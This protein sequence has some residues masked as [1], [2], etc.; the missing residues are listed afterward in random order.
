VQLPELPY[1][2]ADLPGIGGRWKD[3][4]EDFVVEEIPAYEPSGSGEHLFLWIEKRNVAAADL[5]RHVSR[6]LRCSPR[7]I[8]VA[9]L[10]D[11]RAI[12]RQYLSVSAKLAAEVPSIDTD[13]TEIN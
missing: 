8:G 9:G 13:S 7:D 12:T 2:T 5:V 11:R 3:L 4:A 10:K 6:C 1:L